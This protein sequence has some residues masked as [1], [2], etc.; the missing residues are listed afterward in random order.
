MRAPRKR[1]DYVEKHEQF[2]VSLPFRLD[3]TSL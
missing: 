1:W 3:G 2:M